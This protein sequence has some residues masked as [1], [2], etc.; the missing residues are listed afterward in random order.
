[1]KKSDKF[2]NN[3]F[4]IL[5][6]IF[7]ILDINDNNNTFFLSDLDNNIKLQNNI[8]ELEND[9]KTYFACSTWASFSNYNVKRKVLSIIRNLIKNMD[10]CVISKRKFRK[11]DNI[12]YRDTIYYIIKNNHI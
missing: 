2:T 1:M 6:K 4:D 10:Y 11:K 8:L 5:N 7:D 12:S 9:I 3:Q